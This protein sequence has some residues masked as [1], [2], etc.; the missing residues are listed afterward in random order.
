MNN[1]KSAPINGKKIIKDKIGKFN[2]L[3]L[4]MLIILK[5]LSTL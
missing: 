5:S 4:N 3:K 1:I 2:E